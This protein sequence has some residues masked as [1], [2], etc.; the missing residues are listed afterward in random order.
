MLAALLG[1]GQGTFASK[2][3][4][5][6]R[7]R[8]EVTREVDGGAQTVT[9]KLPAIVTTDPAAERAALRLAAQHHEGE[10]EADRRN[11]ARPNIGVDVA[12]RLTILKTSEPATRSAGIKVADVAE[13]V[14]KLRNAPGVI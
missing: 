3:A 12:P 7:Q 4:V 8:C 2:V 11:D 1:W 9:L 5:D 13:L 10:E 6:G 14:G